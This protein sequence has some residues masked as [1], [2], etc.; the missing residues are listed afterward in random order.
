MVTLHLGVLIHIS[1][2]YSEVNI[3]ANCL[4]PQFSEADLSKNMNSLGKKKGDM[5]A[6]YCRRRP[7]DCDESSF[8]TADKGHS[9]SQRSLVRL[10]TIDIVAF[11]SKISLT[12]V[13]T[14]KIHPGA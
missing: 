14:C 2:L 6:L 9:L 4:L 13:G 8:C 11:S 5:S 12:L 10:F 7:Q 3:C 1:V